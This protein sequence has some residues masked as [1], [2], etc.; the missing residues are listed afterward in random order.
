MVGR[1]VPNAPSV[2]FFGSDDFDNSTGP[3]WAELETSAVVNGENEDYVSAVTNRVFVPPANETYAY[4]ADGNQTLVT[5]GTGTWQVEYNGENRPVKW[6]CVSP[7][8]STSLLVSMA[9]DHQGRRRLYF[10]VASGVTNSLHRFTYDDYLCIARNREVDA[11][12]GIGSDGFVWD[13]TEPVATRPLMCNPSTAPLFLYSHDGNK[14]VSE[15]VDVGTGE[16]S[17]HYEY[18][19]FGKMVLVTSERGSN[20]AAINPYRF[21]SEYH[22]DM[23]GLVYYNYRHYNPGDGRW[24]NRDA[25]EETSE[26]NLYVCDCLLLAFSEKLKAMKEFQEIIVFLQNL[27]TSSWNINDIDVLLAKSYSIKELY[28]NYIILKNDN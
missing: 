1:V 24:T 11:R 3:L 27:P 8:T 16:I 17:A 28:A 23:L 15:I 18:S 20:A 10:E 5:T 25:L 19:A 14:N 22:D 7:D 9:Y 26:F 12:H 13:P 6:T 21:S 2:Y 4:D